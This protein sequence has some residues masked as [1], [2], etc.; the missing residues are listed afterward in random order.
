[1]SQFYINTASPLEI[2]DASGHVLVRGQ[3]GRVD[4][5]QSAVKIHLKQ[6]EIAVTTKPFPASTVQYRV[7]GSDGC[8][9]VERGQYAHTF[10]PDAIIGSGLATKS[11]A[12]SFAKELNKS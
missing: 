10:V 7:S 2:C 5:V 3:V 4:Y 12:E 9:Y 1:M 8:W 11:A 6:T